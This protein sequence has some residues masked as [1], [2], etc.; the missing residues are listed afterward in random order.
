MP[1][2]AG[3]FEFFLFDILIEHFNLAVLR[4]VQQQRSQMFSREK[5]ATALRT[6]RPRVHTLLGFKRNSNRGSR[7][8]WYSNNVHAKKKKKIQACNL[9]TI[10]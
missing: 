8:D 10:I 4:P 6:S 3:L 5:G 2:L 9:D 1:E 7:S